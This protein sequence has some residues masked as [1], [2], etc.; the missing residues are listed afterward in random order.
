MSGQIGYDRGS[1][2]MAVDEIL[3]ENLGVI[4]KTLNVLKHPIQSIQDI[5][6]ISE[7]GPRIAEL[8]S[9]YKRLQKEHPN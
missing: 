2:Q 4:G 9:S 1:A 6:S 3:N 8:E 7:L 5:L